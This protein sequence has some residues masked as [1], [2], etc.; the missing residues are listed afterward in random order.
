MI[1]TTKALFSQEEVHQVQAIFFDDIYDQLGEIR[2][3]GISL[4]VIEKSAYMEI[5]MV[6]QESVIEK[7]IVERVILLNGRITYKL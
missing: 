4:K 6:E 7:P 5:D 3:R 1:P 2:P